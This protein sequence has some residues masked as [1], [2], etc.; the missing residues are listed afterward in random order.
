MAELVDAPDSK[1]GDGNIVRVRFSFP[2][3]YL[4]MKTIAKKPAPFFR[5]ICAI[6][7]DLLILTALSII[8]TLCLQLIFNQGKAFAPG[9]HYYQAFL[10]ILW[11][12]YF[13]YFWSHKGQTTGMAAWKIFLIAKN[14]NAYDNINEANSNIN[15]TASFKQI[16]IRIGAAIP[17]F[18]LLGIGFF[19]C[20]IDKEKRTLYDKMAGTEV[21]Y[22]PTRTRG[23]L[24]RSFTHHR[25]P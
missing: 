2:A 18:L 25:S 14:N 1:S 21:I 8:S 23:W 15:K 9:N 17:S 22:T 11:I 13:T 10:M 6:F 3:P 5:R 24:P 19:W 12:G 20:L 16:L 7:Y 4:Y